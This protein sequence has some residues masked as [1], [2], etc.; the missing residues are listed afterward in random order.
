MLRLLLLNL[1]QKCLEIWGIRVSIDQL[2]HCLDSLIE[3]LIVRLYHSFTIAGF[4]M[5]RVKF[6]ALVIVEA[7]LVHFTLFLE[8]HRQ[9]VE[10]RLMDLLKL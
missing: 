2:A 4:D 3:L 10:E 7:R 9:V 5:L 1:L 8:A 6:K